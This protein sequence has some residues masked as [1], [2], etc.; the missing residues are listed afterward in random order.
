M[1]IAPYILYNEPE[2]SDITNKINNLLYIPCDSA[3]KSFY[4]LIGLKPGTQSI[5]QEE[6][7]NNAFLKFSLTSNIRDPSIPSNIIDNLNRTALKGMEYEINLYR[8]ISEYIIRNN[9]CD[10]F[11][12]MIAYTRNCSKQNMSNIFRNIM[13]SRLSQEDSLRYLSY[14][15]KLL[16]GNGTVL[17][18]NEFKSSRRDFDE[19]RLLLNSQSQP[20]SN[21]GY[22][23]L[24]TESMKDNKTLLKTMQNQIGEIVDNDLF[25]YS[26]TTRSIQFSD[27]FYNILFQISYAFKI[28]DKF[29][30]IHNDIHPGN[31][32]IKNNNRPIIRRYIVKNNGID[33]TCDLTSN[34]EALIYDF[35]RGYM[36]SLGRNEVLTYRESGY[37]QSNEFVRGK[38]LLKIFVNIFLRCKRLF[39]NKNPGILWTSTDNCKDLLL[40]FLNEDKIM[41]PRSQLNEFINQSSDQNIHFLRNKRNIP[42]QSVFYN[43]NI[44]SFDQ[45]ELN[46]LQKISSVS[47][48]TSGLLTPDKTFSIPTDQI[49]QN[50][51]HQINQ[52][53]AIE[54]RPEIEP[55]V[56]SQSRTQKQAF[57]LKKEQI[58]IA[59]QNIPRILLQIQNLNQNV[60][61]LS[62]KS[63][64][65]V[66]IVRNYNIFKDEAGQLLASN[67][68]KDDF[69]NTRLNV[70][71]LITRQGDIK[72]EKIEE[73][74]T[75][76]SRKEEYITTLRHLT[77][78][79][80]QN[81][82]FMRSNIGQNV[83]INRKVQDNITILENQL[84]ILNRIDLLIQNLYNTQIGIND[85]NRVINTDLI[86]L[87]NRLD[88]NI[89]DLENL[90]R[91]LIELNT[92]TENTYNISQY[93]T[94]HNEKLN[95]REEY[96]KNLERNISS[97]ETD[98]K[99]IEEDFE[100]YQST[101]NNDIENLIILCER[102]KE[103]V[104]DSKAVKN[105]DDL[106]KREN[107][108]SLNYDM[109]RDIRY[110]INRGL[111]RYNA[112][113][114]QLPEDL[115]NV[116]LIQIKENINSL[117]LEQKTKVE[118]LKELSNTSLREEEVDR[119][120]KDLE[121]R[122]N[123]IYNNL[124]GDNKLF[125]NLVNSIET[126]VKYILEPFSE[127]Q[128]RFENS[129]RTQEN[130]EM[131]RVINEN[132][133]RINKGVYDMEGLQVI[134][135]FLY[136]SEKR[137]ILE[138]N[139]TDLIQKRLRIDRFSEIFRAY[140]FDFNQRIYEI[141][142]LFNS[143]LNEVNLILNMTRT[144]QSS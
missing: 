108:I 42:L 102:F 31:I 133:N 107:T 104:D 61:S 10:S 26:Y 75:N 44:L 136:L 34:K 103:I 109:I 113:K 106:I 96:G 77:T 120:F 32:W 6:V 55:I 67:I 48:N 11:V 13:N 16:S 127:I 60:Q 53:I 129:W 68:D 19:S 58:D 92:Y 4:Y 63:S 111:E 29:R 73:Y 30:I 65:I 141:Q 132:Y 83:Y 23:F 89:L 79:I 7:I 91:Y 78:S 38:D 36:E 114:G 14:L 15:T 12:K 45:I 143:S 50:Y 82:D 86:I 88:K 80:K 49:I 46:I 5:E 2:C 81:I 41:D 59:E 134:N 142:D 105:A 71:N 98:I 18:F 137:D 117:I 28:L 87:L 101:T 47:K 69:V 112:I 125:K 100:K 27:D 122:F 22:C 56:Y 62:D 51:I 37:S 54:K 33:E 17:K 3:S 115:T 52:T 66:N 118:E 57:I 128:R 25:R 72:I 74:N 40:I 124:Y 119:V 43:E 131:K 123:E 70:L 110:R 95:K 99:S 39:E 85:E 9:I 76:I 135:I 138:I 35:D 121:T 20:D 64:E 21:Y 94:I 93:I 24:I 84:V 130:E 1:N 116:S 140:I 97:I 90:N 126:L 8:V 139:L 144:L